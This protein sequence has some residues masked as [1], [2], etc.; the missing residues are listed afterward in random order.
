MVALAPRYQARMMTTVPV[1]PSTARYVPITEIR[2]PGEVLLS[3]YKPTVTDAPATGVLVSSST[4]TFTSVSVKAFAPVLNEFPS[5]PS[6]E[7]LIE[8]LKLLEN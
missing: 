7:A 1:P 8:S 6:V 5:G 4:F 2:E 3:A